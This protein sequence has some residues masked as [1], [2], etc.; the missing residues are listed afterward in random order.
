M[1]NSNF[2]RYSN[3]H[4]N[5]VTTDKYCHNEHGRSNLLIR[6]DNVHYRKT[7]SM[8]DAIKH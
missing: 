1:G 5:Y 7:S 2:G 4:G 8:S 3:E 6:H